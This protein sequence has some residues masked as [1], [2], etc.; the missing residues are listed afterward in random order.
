MIETLYQG[1]VGVA[2]PALR[3][4]LAHRQKQG[5]EDPLRLGERLGIASQDRPPGGLAWMHAASVGESLSVLPLA[6]RL[7]RQ[8]PDVALLFTS[9]TVTSARLLAERLPAGCIHQYSALDVPAWVER[10]LD[11]WRPGAVLWVESEF[12]PNTLAILRRRRIPAAL[13]NARM[14]P[15]SFS[16]WQRV[17]SLI[18]PPLDLFDP[19]LAQD[20]TIAARLTALGARQVRCLGNLK[21]DAEPLPA[22]GAALADLQAALGRRPA[23]LAASLH[24]A[25]VPALADAHRT[26]AARHHG[27]V[28]IVVPRHPAKGGEM[29]EA[30]SGSG[31]TVAQ[32]SHG[33]M[34]GGAD[35][36][37]ADTLGELGL[38]Y[39]ATRVVL[40]GG[41]L[42]PHGGQ[43][44][45]EAA[46]LGCA[47]VLGPHMF[48]FP[49]MTPSLLAAGAAEQI[50]DGT[51]LA[52][53][54]D[55]LLTDADLANR[56]G[57]AARQMAESGRGA[58]ERVAS[59]LSSL[60]APLSA[61]AETD[62]ARA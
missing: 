40:I 61:A 36:Y 42:I 5:K 25:E 55:R 35:I 54:I 7:R 56:R 52:S 49:E 8:W 34:P 33:M 3:L 45:L 21:F 18:R 16:R 47:L 20:E 58:V 1:L 62:R 38:F 23:W 19:C 2:A 60:I 29:A 31:L 32:R 44:P 51:A 46:R 11:H 41:S 27:L 59:A 10:F 15:R 14:S 17:S 13:V 39:R 6:A 22:A 43:N 57:T 37:I 9:G 4:W 28:T 30:F 26:L 48:N 53:A 50:A 24:P 12:W